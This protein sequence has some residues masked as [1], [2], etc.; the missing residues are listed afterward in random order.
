VTGDGKAVVSVRAAVAAL[1][2]GDVDGYLGHFDPSCLRWAD[3]LA[4]PL[5]L[6]AVEEGLRQLNAAFE[7]FR[8][9]TALLFGDDRYACAHWRM[10]GLHVKDYFGIKATGRSIDVATCEVYEVSDGRVVNTWVH[11][12]LADLFDQ[13]APKDGG[14]A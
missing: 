8:L 4:Q 1:N 14:A 5:S 7:G 13:I 10:L 2:D 9:D 6:S 3:G 11:G 12:N